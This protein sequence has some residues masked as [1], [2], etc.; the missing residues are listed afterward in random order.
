MKFDFYALSQQDLSNQPFA[1]VTF[2]DPTTKQLLFKTTLNL[3]VKVKYAQINVSPDRTLNFGDF[4]HGKDTQ[5]T[6]TIENTGSFPTQFA[7]EKIS[8]ALKRFLMTGSV[9]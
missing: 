6:I 3:S 7:I 2:C 4:A 8:A 9:S 5:K 1:N